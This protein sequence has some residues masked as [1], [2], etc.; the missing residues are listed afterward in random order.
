MFAEK[1]AT[2]TLVCCC[3]HAHLNIV[4]FTNSEHNSGLLFSFARTVYRLPG[5]R[6]IKKTE[7]SLKLIKDEHQS[8]MNQKSLVRVTAQYGMGRHTSD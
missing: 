4:E 5:R 1:H 6:F 7:T 2:Y 8:T 3:L